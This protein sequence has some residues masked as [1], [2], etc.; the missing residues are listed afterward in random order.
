MNPIATALLGDQMRHTGLARS[1]YLRWFTD[2][3]ERPASGWT[4]A[5]PLRS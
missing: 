2:A 1:A 3:A 4:E 5:T